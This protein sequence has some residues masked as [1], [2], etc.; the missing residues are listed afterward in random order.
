MIRDYSIANAAVSY[1]TDPT[2]IIHH[3]DTTKVDDLRKIQKFTQ[4]LSDANVDLGELKRYMGV[5][6]L[7]YSLFLFVAA[8]RKLSWS[9]VPKD[10]RLVV[11]QLLFG[12]LPCNQARRAETLARKRKEYADSVAASY[13]RGTAGLDQ[14]LW[15]QVYNCERRV[16]ERLN[17]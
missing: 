3:I 11:W 1:H 7:S 4:V 16:I 15:H 14:T 8:L 5:F 9:G 13:S 17:G 2:N 10:L 6:S 12:Y